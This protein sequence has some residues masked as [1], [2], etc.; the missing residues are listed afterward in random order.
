M[1][2]SP[3][4]EGILLAIETEKHMK[5]NYASK[6]VS[7]FVAI[8]VSV[9]IFCMF[10]AGFN[11]A[12]QSVRGDVFT[13]MFGTIS[14]TGDGYNVVW[15]LVIGFVLL[16]LAFVVAIVGLFLGEDAGKIVAVCEALLT[17]GAGILFLF[18]IQFY[19]SANAGKIS[20]LDLTG[21]TYLGAGSIC[22]SVFSFLATA[23]SLI[24]LLVMN[25]KD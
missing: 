2:L 6:I 20:D 7:A 19:I 14:S 16:L 8:F 23:T 18:A 10:A 4:R 3:P 25:K 11:E 22:V 15:P 24:G 5:K 17:A 13:I 1:L 9:A 21:K 12:M